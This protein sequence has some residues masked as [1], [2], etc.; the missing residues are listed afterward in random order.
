MKTMKKIMFSLA[1][2]LAG[3]NSVYANDSS[4]KILND[5]T[6]S[7]LVASVDDVYAGKATP[8]KM[9]GL[10]ITSGKSYDCEYAIESGYLSG[11]FTVGPHT[12]IMNSK[13]EITG[14]GTYAVSGKITLGFIN[15]SFSGNVIVTEADGSNLE[16]SCHVVTENLGAVSE[17][18]FVGTK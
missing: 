16:F 1:L 12:V 5:D 8:T 14:A 17:F 10:P 2:I 7:V 15:F 11:S 6:M 13:E 18:S 3:L 4:R 9:N